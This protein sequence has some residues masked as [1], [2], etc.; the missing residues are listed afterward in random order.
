MTKPLDLKHIPLADLHISKLNMRNKTKGNTPPDIS[1]ILPSIKERGIRQPILVRPEP[2]KVNKNAYGVIAG[3][4]RY[5][6]LKSITDDGGKI[7]PVPCCI[8]DADDDAL[9]LE[10]SILENIARLA[11]T[12][13]EQAQAFKKLADKGESIAEIAAVFGITERAVKQRLALGSLLP[14]LRKLYTD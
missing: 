1:D 3:R 2:T 9:G 8:M 4:R 14:E 13:M 7:A 6:C 10:A 12:E 5:F 11:P